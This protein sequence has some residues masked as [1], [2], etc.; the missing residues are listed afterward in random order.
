MS[1]KSS[2]IELFGMPGSGKSY[3]SNLIGSILKKR[4][5]KVCNAREI[6]INDSE[7][8]IK[9]NFF[10][11][12]SLIYFSLINFKNKK[13]LS[14]KKQFSQTKKNLIKIKN[15]SNFFKQNYL[16]VCK[17]IIKTKKEYSQL[18]NKIDKS[19]NIKS[20]LEK[21]QYL[22][23]IYELLAAK[24]LFKKYL[25]SKKNYIFLLDEGFVQRSFTLNKIFNKKNDKQF[26][27]NFFSKIPL[28]DIII[29]IKLPK[30]KILV[31]NE[32]R[33]IKDLKKYKTKKELSVMSKFLD[34]YLLKQKKFLYLTI[35]NNENLDL[36]I[37]N[38][39]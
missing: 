34:V 8:L 15:T 7:K 24:I 26:F 32:K 30:Q 27:N 29:F 36:L 1:Q 23:W 10:E 19:F 20:S 6:I 21:R 2:S 39:F 5:Y 14:K 16:A 17:K 25:I 13:F 12:I 9:L 33:K 38:L 28:S 22:F 18:L 35:K 11:K 31:Q 3:Y 37:K 4:G